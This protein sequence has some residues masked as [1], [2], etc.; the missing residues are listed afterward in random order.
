MSIRSERA[1]RTCSTG[2]RQPPLQPLAP[3]GRHIEQRPPRAGRRSPRFR[4][5]GSARAREHVERAVD[6]RP[7]HRP[8]AP[9]LAAGR[10]R[11]CDGEAVRGVSATSASAAHSPVASSSERRRIGAEA[12]TPRAMSPVGGIHARARD[13]SPRPAILRLDVGVRDGA[14]A[15]RASRGAG[16]GGDAGPRA[17]AACTRAGSAARTCRRSWVSAT[18]SWTS[19]VA[20]LPAA[21]G[22]RRSGR[23]RVAGRHARGRLGR[24]A[25][26]LAEY[27]IARVDN[28]LEIDRELSDTDATVIQPLCTVLHALD[29]LGDV[30]GRHVAV[31]ARGRSESCSA[32]R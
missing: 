24:G 16:A 4:P 20:G 19:T 30:A 11:P 25:L 6:E 28:V 5:R 2:A 22:R 9:H 18:R 32:T 14:R 1:S 3:G 26:G 13:V 15:A 27:F 31:S 21:R 10:H 23:R 7:P 29:R 17:G 12:I 8:H